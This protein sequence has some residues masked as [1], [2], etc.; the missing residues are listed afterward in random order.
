M[1]AIGVLAILVIGAAGLW[2]GI[3]NIAPRTSLSDLVSLGLVDAAMGNRP[4]RRY[5]RQVGDYHACQK[6]NERQNDYQRGTA[7]ASSA[8]NKYGIHPGIV[9]MEGGV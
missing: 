6:H 3:H 9:Q 5:A 8:S 1:I 4:V 2:T 7:L